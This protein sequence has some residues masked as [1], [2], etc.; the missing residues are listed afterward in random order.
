MSLRWPLCDFFK[1]PQKNVFVVSVISSYFRMTS[2]FV[3][4]KHFLG[5]SQSSLQQLFGARS[6]LKNDR[7]ELMV[8]TFFVST[9]IHLVAKPQQ[10]IYF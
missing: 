9:A 8:W 1:V 10:Y 4:L 5:L 2:H 6:S 3:G 7:N